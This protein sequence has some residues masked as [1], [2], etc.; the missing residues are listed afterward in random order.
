MVRSHEYNRFICAPMVFR[1]YLRHFC[2]KLHK[3]QLLLLTLRRPN[4]SVKL[5]MLSTDRIRKWKPY[6]E[7]IWVDFV[8]VVMQPCS[9]LHRIGTEMFWNC[10]W[11]SCY[12]PVYAPC[13]C[14]VWNIAQFASRL[15]KKQMLAV[16]LKSFCLKVPKDETGKCSFS[17]HVHLHRKCARRLVNDLVLILLQWPREIDTGCCKVD[18]LLLCCRKNIFVPTR[19][20]VAKAGLHPKKVNCYIF[21]APAIPSRLIFVPHPWKQSERENIQNSPRCQQ[22]FRSGFCQKFA[23]TVRSWSN[24]ITKSVEKDDGT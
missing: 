20:A 13:C 17:P 16:R 18:C 21:G 14:I 3:R 15:R 19:W 2:T 12:G 6:A 10:C 23:G 5:K 9:T 4:L 22:A 11:V 1:R 8:C 7:K 24:G